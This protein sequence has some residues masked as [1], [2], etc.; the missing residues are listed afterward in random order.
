MA[1]LP[2]ISRLPDILDM[3]INNY[4]NYTSLARY[5]TF[6]RCVCSLFSSQ[7]NSIK[8]DCGCTGQLPVQQY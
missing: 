6:N 5:Q 1:R 8:P 4:N 7:F 3:I 2:V